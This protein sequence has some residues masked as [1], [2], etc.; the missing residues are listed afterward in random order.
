MT[1]LAALAAYTVLQEGAAEPPAGSLVLTEGPAGTA[2][3]RLHST[4][5]WHS[6]T[7]RQLPWRDLERK[8]TR[9]GAWPLLLVYVPG[10]D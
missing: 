7:G 5:D 2:W 4:G 1:G 10:E 3:Q 8:T 6:S 9:P